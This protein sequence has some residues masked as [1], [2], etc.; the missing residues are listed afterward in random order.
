MTTPMIPND[1]FSDSA[2]LEADLFVQ[3]SL[4]WSRALFTSNIVAASR[5]QDPDVIETLRIEA[6]YQ[7]SEFF[8]L[9][10]ARGIESVE[11]ISGLAD[12]H[13][14]H[15]DSLS[16]DADKMKRLGLNRKRVLDA[17]FTA[18]TMPRLV[19]IWRERP[20][21]LDQSN[22]AR[23]LATVMSTETCRKLIV[24]ASQA[25]F[26]ERR[27][28]PHGTV[29][30]GSNGIVERVFGGVLRDLRHRVQAQRI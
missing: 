16:R 15:L 28:S 23:F 18:D 30:V 3:E 10:R 1:I 20:G 19:E 7:F 27:K 26:L 6:M 12:V 8:Y 22:L 11:A 5:S 17:I 9:L 14:R 29:I 4:L 2:A 25:G 24:A 13:N 21:H